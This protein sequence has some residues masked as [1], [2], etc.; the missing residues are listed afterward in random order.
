MLDIALSAP[1]PMI[2]LSTVFWRDCVLRLYIAGS[3]PTSFCSS[4]G[5]SID[6][7]DTAISCYSG[8][9]T[10]SHVLV[11]GASSEC[12]NG[13]IIRKFLIIAGSITGAMLVS[14]AMF[15]R[16]R[17]GLGIKSGGGVDGNETSIS[18]DSNKDAN[19][20]CCTDDEVEGK[21]ADCS[22]GPAPTLILD[23]PSKL[24][25]QWFGQYASSTVVLITLAKLLAAVLFTM[26][27]YDWWKY[28]NE[29][30]NDTLVQSCS[31]PTVGNCRSYCSDV[32]IVHVN[33]THDDYQFDD[34]L[35]VPQ[36]SRSS[37]YSNSE[38]CVA[39]FRGHCAY[40]YWLVFKLVPILLHVVG[41][42]L[43]C[44]T[45]Y[46]L[47]L[48]VPQ[49]KQ[50]DTLIAHRYPD[51]YT[52]TNRSCYGADTDVKRSRSRCGRTATAT[53]S[54]NSVLIAP[55]FSELNKTPIYNVFAFLEVFIVVYV[56][57]ELWYPPIYCDAV[58]PLSLYYYPLL[59][60]AL[61]LAKFNVY[62]STR[63]CA[64]GR[65]EDAL[66]ACLNL[67]MFLTST[68]V[69]VLLAGMFVV[70]LA[71]DCIQRIRWMCIFIYYKVQGERAM[72]TAWPAA[73]AAKTV[74]EATRA[75]NS[76]LE[77]LQNSGDTCNPMR[78]GN[79]SA[80]VDDS[81]P[82]EGIQLSGIDVTN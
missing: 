15:H 37:Y 64:I 65:Y 54:M 4:N 2:S 53:D 55:L 12:H 69:N 45:W 13:H 59:M 25:P 6:V 73:I 68:C 52:S 29:D 36:T 24:L 57:G 27:Y 66:L 26:T 75:G 77:A 32:V 51:L 81:Y 48:F 79:D 72:E 47:K 70:D 10:S 31:N 46:H 20:D 17:F 5:M 42:L 82:E 76:D 21:Q 49:Q 30:D 14:T 22:L 61:E 28:S 7:S 60:S 62:V 41:F 16:R 39:E 34:N 78:A 23:E 19:M 67:E 74:M 58:R 35:I 63:L 50:Y 80:M 56:W 3:I 33:I 1:V 9:L 40:S 18:K 71:V 11:Y 8:C 38:Y 43:Q 44:L